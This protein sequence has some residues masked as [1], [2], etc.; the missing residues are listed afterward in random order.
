LLEQR[1][2][3]ADIARAVARFNKRKNVRP[4]SADSGI[5]Y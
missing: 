1:E 4:T 3:L 2:N 5:I